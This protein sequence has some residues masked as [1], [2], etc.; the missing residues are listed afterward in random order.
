MVHENGGD[1]DRLLEVSKK[2]KEWATLPATDKLA[3]LEEIYAIITKEMEFGEWQDIGK[4][5]AEMMGFDTTNTAEG[6]AE[7]TS[8]TFLLAMVA[9]DEIEHLL[10]AYRVR[11]GITKPP[12]QL[13]KGNY[14]TRTAINGQVVLKTFPILPMDKMGIAPHI[15]GEV[16]M[17]PSK[18]RDESEVEAFAFDKAWGED[19]ADVKEGGLEVVLGAGN[20][21]ALTFSDVAQAMFVRNY[22]VYLKQHPLRNFVNSLLKR[23]FAPLIARGYLALEDHTTNERCA[24]LVYHPTVDALHITGGKPTHD[25]LVWGADPKERER[26]LRENTPKIKAVTS[27]LGAVSPW[28]VV[29]GKYK[30]KEL[31]TQASI[32]AMFVHNNASCNCNAVKCIVVAEEWD[33]KEEFLRLVEDALSNHPLPVPYYPNIEERWKA[34]CD[35]YPNGKKI[36]SKTGMGIGERNLTA[37]GLNTGK[38]FLLPYLKI[39]ARV[40]LGSPAGKEAASNEFAFKNEPFA[41]VFTVATLQGTSQT[42]LMQFAKT[43]ST[44]CNDYLFG[45]LSGAI[46]TPPSLL[47][48]DSVQTLIA[49]MK[50]GTVGVN[51]W[52][53]FGYVLR[54]S[55]MWGAFPG[56]TLDNVQSGIGKIGNSLAVPYFQKMVFVAPITHPNNFFL[57]TDFDA[58]R[59]RFEAISKFFLYKGVGNLIDL[60]SAVTGVNLKIVGLALSSAAAA[61]LAGYYLSQ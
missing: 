43:S 17:D 42:D 21:N 4:A 40:D 32:I 7:A 59:R 30:P 8:Q 23:I 33:Q 11:A 37:G 54:N 26:N 38:P 36:G 48:D 44:F 39:E 18:I 60:L 13:T 41:P 45:T 49:E 15:H 58:E 52:N 50:Y 9:K 16:W 35:Q 10:F 34:F 14:E 55:G 53:G 24:A 5:T 19:A 3:I 56:E 57:S 12:K 27:E 51:N 1:F 6:K 20:Y 31:K 46:T 61:G 22:V 28:V 29:P 25:L 2:R 47:K